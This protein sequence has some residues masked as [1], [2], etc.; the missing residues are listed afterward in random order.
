MDG[1]GEAASYE[2]IPAQWRVFSVHNTFDQ[3]QLNGFHQVKSPSAS[4]ADSPSVVASADSAPI[5]A[6]SG[7]IELYVA[8]PPSD[9]SINT[10][11]NGIK[12]FFIKHVP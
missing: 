8:Q 9:T 4:L 2:K 6:Q 7:A 11:K 5:C 12:T 3:N 10:I 1:I